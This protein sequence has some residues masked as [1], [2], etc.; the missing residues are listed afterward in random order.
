MNVIDETPK[1]IGS[2]GGL[3]EKRHTDLLVTGSFKNE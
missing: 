2:F 1:E 3:H